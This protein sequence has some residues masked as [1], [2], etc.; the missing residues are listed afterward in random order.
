MR[1]SIALAANRAA[2]CILIEAHTTEAIERIQRYTGGLDKAGFVRSQLVQ[3]AVIR[4]F[5]IL[6]EASR[7]IERRS[8]TDTSRSICRSSR[9][10][11]GTIWHPCFAL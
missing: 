3:D 7:N 9:R 11:S 4:N 6:G 10:R 2:I 5:E 1:P 8:P